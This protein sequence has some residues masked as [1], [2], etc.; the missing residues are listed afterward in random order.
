MT[1]KLQKAEALAEAVRDLMTLIRHQLP[2]GIERQIAEELDAVKAAIASFDAAPENHAYKAEQE[3]TS[4]LAR[5]L[6]AESILWRSE[7]CLIIARC[8]A[9]TKNRSRYDSVLK[10]INSIK[11]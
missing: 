1:T 2:I 9:S 5:A 11:P 4:I 10:E 6:K 3:T 8:V 7:T